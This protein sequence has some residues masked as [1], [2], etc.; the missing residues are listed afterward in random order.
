ML[1]V[2][3]AVNPVESLVAGPIVG[4]LTLGVGVTTLVPLAVPEELPVVDG[5]G[6]SF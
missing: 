5:V 6:V 2:G 4:L 3:S 1:I